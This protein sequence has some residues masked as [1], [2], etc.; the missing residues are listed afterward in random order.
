MN[1]VKKLK[2]EMF[3][4]YVLFSTYFIGFTCFSKYCHKIHLQNVTLYFFDIKIALLLILFEFGKL[5]Y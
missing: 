4:K 1:Q 5:L 3:A 2:T